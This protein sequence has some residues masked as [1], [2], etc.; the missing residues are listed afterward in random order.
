M[1]HG[2][3]HILRTQHIRP[4]WYSFYNLFSQNSTPVFCIKPLFLSGKFCTPRE[5][6]FKT[7][8]HCKLTAVKRSVKKPLN[9]IFFVS[10][11]VKRKVFTIFSIYF[12]FLEQM[13][14]QNTIHATFAII[15]TIFTNS[16]FSFRVNMWIVTSVIFHAFINQGSGPQGGVNLWRLKP[17][18]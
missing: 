6:A 1:V 17:P 13:Y 2:G 7:W 12:C 8:K 11:I 18:R 9:R 10:P 16:S 5:S 14:V 3:L 15:N 4:P